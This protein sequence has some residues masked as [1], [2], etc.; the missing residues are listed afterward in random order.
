MKHLRLL[1]AFFALAVA[2]MG[3]SQAQSLGDMYAAAKK[4]DATFRAAQVQFEVSRA[5]AD[6]ALAGVL[7]RAS[8]GISTARNVADVEPFGPGSS[9]SSPATRYFSTHSGTLNASHPLYNPANRLFYEQSRKQLAQ[10]VQAL[11]TAEQDLLVKTSQAYFDVLASQDTLNFVKAQRSAVSEQLAAAKRNF[12]VGTATITDT[13]EA[14]ARFDLIRAQE[15]AAENDLRVKRLALDQLVGLTNA[16]P[17]PLKNQA[18]LLSPQPQ[19]AEAWVTQAMREHPSLLTAQLNAEVA[20]MEIE[21]ARTGHLPTLDLQA[22]VGQIRNAGGTA[23][24]GLST[25]VQSQ[26]VGLALTLPLFSGFSVQN[27]IAETLS[28]EEKARLDLEAARRSVAQAVR[29]AYLG[30]ESGLGQV[31][32]LEA[33]ESSSQL[34]LDANKLGYNVGVRINIDVLNSQSQLY[35]TK[36]DLAKARYDVL[37]GGLKL[38]QANGSL[39]VED[40]QAV[41]ALLN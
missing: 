19:D 31:K 13:R 10:A 34:A 40:L 6:Q 14:E 25:Q 35:Q 17:R 21:R 3:S 20:Q 8:L 33:A 9:S 5:R 39:K 30:L 22:S 29:T 32:A 1:S 41:N 37:L 4:H 38:R 7:P 28:L 18:S 11:V 24:S 36:R 12:E 2:C 16:Q 23:I 15:I 26:S 27:R